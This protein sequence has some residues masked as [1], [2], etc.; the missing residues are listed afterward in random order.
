[1]ID[2]IIIIIGRERERDANVPMF[3]LKKKG[4]IAP[5]DFFNC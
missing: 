4:Y 1:V 2:I 5:R 3:Q